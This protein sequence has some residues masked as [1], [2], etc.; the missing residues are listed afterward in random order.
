[1]VS[2][3]RQPATAPYG[4]HSCVLIKC[5]ISLSY[6]EATASDRSKWKDI[7]SHG[8]D[9]CSHELD[10]AAEDRRSRKHNAAKIAPAGQSVHTAAVSVP[11]S[12]VSLAISASTLLIPQHSQHHKRPR[13][14]RQTTE[15]DRERARNC[16]LAA[17]ALLK[18]E[19]ISSTGSPGFHGRR[20]CDIL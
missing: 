12:L 19:F 11:P 10:Q 16:C 3:S 18:R 1:V 7:C 5:N 20:L 8:L 17:Q 14:T 15:R 13:R 6:L 2:G 9:A 4:P